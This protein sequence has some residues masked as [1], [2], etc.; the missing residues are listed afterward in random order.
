MNFS[1]RAHGKVSF[2]VNLPQSDVAILRD[3]FSRYNGKRRPPCPRAQ[4]LDR[5]AD[6]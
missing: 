3:L 2:E 6:L 5:G 1:M 4:A